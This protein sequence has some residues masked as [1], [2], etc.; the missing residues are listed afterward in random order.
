MS[1]CCLIWPRFKRLS[2][3]V[4]EAVNRDC[5]GVSSWTSWLYPPVP[6]PL[7]DSAC[8]LN[9]D[10][11]TLCAWPSWPPANQAGALPVALAPPACT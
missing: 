8:V 1:R 10:I 2:A 4:V 5:P 3:C 11:T 6:V 7:S 9:P